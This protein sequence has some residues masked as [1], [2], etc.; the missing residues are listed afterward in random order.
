MRTH[1]RVDD[2]ASPL[3][4]PHFIFNFD[5]LYDKE[6]LVENKNKERLQS[7]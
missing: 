7:L 3:I 4:C 6:R 5:K 1:I 2:L